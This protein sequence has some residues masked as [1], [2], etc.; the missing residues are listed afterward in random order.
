MSDKLHSDSTQASGPYCAGVL[1]IASMDTQVFGISL[2][3]IL[4]PRCS[5]I[6]TEFRRWF[7]EGNTNFGGEH[8]V[9]KTLKKTWVKK[10]FDIF[11][12][13]FRENTF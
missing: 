1:G 2:M 7:I 8:F 3:G 9:I 10:K 13:Q 12:T 6:S 4:Q 11:V 5:T